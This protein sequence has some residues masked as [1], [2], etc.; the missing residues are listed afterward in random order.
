MLPQHPT[1]LAIHAKAKH[2]QGALLW[3]I[4]CTEAQATHSQSSG[5]ILCFTVYF[6]Y[7]LHWTVKE[8]APLTKGT[9]MLLRTLLVMPVER[10]APSCIQWSIFCSWKSTV[11]SAK[12]VSESGRRRKRVGTGGTGHDKPLLS[13]DALAQAT[14]CACMCCF[15]RDGIKEIVQEHLVSARYP[16]TSVPSLRLSKIQCLAWYTNYPGHIYCLKQFNTSLKESKHTGWVLVFTQSVK[17]RKLLCA[18]TKDTFQSQKRFFHIHIQI[19][20]L[21]PTE[22]S[23]LAF[24]IKTLCG[25]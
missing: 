18:Q 12:E 21:F 14:V 8:S 10:L 11:S 17:Q 4:K 23:I 24:L 6:L 7:R 2:S 13:V 20:Y 22:T 5:P 1:L 19:W 15:N 9:L 16:R 3:T 25:S